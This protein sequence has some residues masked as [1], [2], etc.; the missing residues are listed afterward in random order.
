MEWQ[1]SRRKSSEI[2]LQGIVGWRRGSI[3]ESRR[4][5]YDGAAKGY[6]G[7]PDAK[8]S[9]NGFRTELSSGSAGQLTFEGG[10]FSR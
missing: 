6:Q 9:G 10:E 3:S 1:V 7:A 5:T 8:T 2:R 4:T